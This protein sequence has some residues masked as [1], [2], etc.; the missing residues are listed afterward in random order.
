MA[1]CHIF[2]LYFVKELF[3]SHKI[4][5]G[6]YPFLVKDLFISDIIYNV[7]KNKGIP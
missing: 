2:I 6:F 1:I 7:S 4:V 5:K 3:Y